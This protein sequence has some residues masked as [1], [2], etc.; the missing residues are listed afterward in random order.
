MTQRAAF[1]WLITVLCWL[2]S[3]A[4]RASAAGVWILWSESWREDDTHPSGPTESKWEVLAAA[5]TPG[6]CQRA[7]LGWIQR[8]ALI[9]RESGIFAQRE[10]GKPEG[11]ANRLRPVCL[12]D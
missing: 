5:P 8:F 10:P 4:P 12:P 6:S 2:I 11:T 1:I 3:V 9:P 7:R